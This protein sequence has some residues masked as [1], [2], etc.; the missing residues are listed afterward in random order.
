MKIK[1]I[2]QFAEN[3]N[4]PESLIRAVIRQFGGWESFKESYKDVVRHGIDGGFHGF[5]YHKDTVAFAK[6]NKE[7]ILWLCKDW[8]EQLGEGGIIS[9]ISTFGCLKGETQ[10]DIA[11]GLYNPKSENQTLIYNALAWFA[12]EEVCR[13][14]D[15]LVSQD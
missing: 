11:D 3:S 2:K 13:A 12:A 10:E 1:T 6:C 9:F 8:A 4:I 14:Y 5:I 7:S 15:D